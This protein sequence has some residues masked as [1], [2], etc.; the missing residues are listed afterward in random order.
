MSAHVGLDPVYRKL[1][2]EYIGGH[3]ACLHRHNDDRGKGEEIEYVP[4]SSAQ[5]SHALK[6]NRRSADEKHGRQCQEQERR[7]HHRD[8]ESLSPEKLHENGGDSH[9]P[10]HDRQ[11]REIA[12]ELSH[13]V[14]RR[15][16]RG[17]CE[18]LPHA[19]LPVP[20]DGIFHD[21]KSDEGD[22][23]YGAE[24]HRHA[25]PGRVGHRPGVAHVNAD[26]PVIDEVPKVECRGDSHEEAVTARSLEYVGLHE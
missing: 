11:D 25:G 7:H 19:R 2:A 5:E 10:R 26:R 15:S 17:S 1:Q 16:H 8:V 4:E 24:C 22:E 9:N 23:C 12:E 20:L 21:V 14:K 6:K 13:H 18:Y 3:D